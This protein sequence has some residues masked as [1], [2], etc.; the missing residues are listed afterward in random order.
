[1]FKNDLGTLCVDICSH[2]AVWKSIYEIDIKVPLGFQHLPTIHSTKVEQMLGKCWTNRLNGLSKRP[3]RHLSFS[4]GKENVEAMLNDS[5]N[6]LKFDSTRLQQAF[7][8]LHF[9][10]C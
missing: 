3:Q 9:K 1:M 6:Q 4:R 5:L 7:F 2:G 8:F 10:Q